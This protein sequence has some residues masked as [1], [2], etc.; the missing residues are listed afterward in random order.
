MILTSKLCAERPFAGRNTQQVGKKID[1][2]EGQNSYLLHG[3]VKKSAQF[4]FNKK[5]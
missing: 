5:K 3:K 2:K 1:K 4:V